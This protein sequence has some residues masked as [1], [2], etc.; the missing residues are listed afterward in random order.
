LNFFDEQTATDLEFDDI[1]LLLKD[2]C[3]NE[4][5]KFWS[6]KIRPFRT[7]AQAEEALMLTHELQLIRNRGLTFPRLE[8]NE[9]QKEIR[10]LEITA[11]VL[12]LQSIVNIW[13]ASKL[14]NSL[15]L[16]FKEER[17]YTFLPSLL[18]GAFFTK[19]IDAAIEKI[20][21]KRLE[22]KDDASESLFQIRQAIHSTKRK[23]SRNFERALKSAQKQGYI[24]DINESV[25]DDRR[26]LSINSTFKRQ[27]EGNILGNSK[28]G[29]LTYIEPRANEK[30]NNELA[31]L[32]DDERKEIQKIF[33]E[34]TNFLRGFYDLIQVY[35]RAL[36]K[37]DFINA[38][39]WLAAKMDAVKPQINK[40]GTETHLHDAYHPL[41]LL[42]NNLLGLKTFPQ[43]FQ[44]DKDQ[45]IMVISGPNAGGK[46]ITLK[47]LGIL[48][49]MFQSGLLV[50][51][52]SSS[53]FSWYNYILS[54]IGDN[55]SIE[56]QLS[57]YSY[58]LQ[59][60]KFFLDKTSPKTLLL[61][62]E[63]GTGSDPD[64]G[65]ALAEVF[66]ETI[67]EKGCY[68]VI[69]THYTNI[70]LKASEL[71]EAFNANMLFN[72]KTLEPEY[73]LSVGQAGSSFTFEVAE[74]N[75]IPNELLQSAKKKI[76]RNK[77]KLDGLISDLQKEKSNLK[78][79]RKKFS[80]KIQET[81]KAKS[82]FEKFQNRYD[83]RLRV[84]QIR[85]ERNDKYLGH[86]KKM[87]DFIDRFQFNGGQKNKGLLN[88]VRKYITIEKS[89]IVELELK[90]VEKEKEK[91][92]KS[93]S[94]KP[95]KQLQT[96]KRPIVKGSRVKLKDSKQTG[97]VIELE[98]K[99]AVVTFGMF[100]TKVSTDKLILIDDLKTKK[101]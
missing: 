90:K 1:R 20:L 87:S 35:Q 12:E 83:E 71:A 79:E 70:K 80:E 76:D 15:M 28:T 94:K 5:A 19:E 49:L 50:C 81:E 95:K 46:S 92:K 31:Q 89:K 25:I 69:T 18:E 44:L 100:K 13:D 54:D 73:Q 48:Q 7:L 24:S 38:K 9:L 11:S 39:V 75:G 82:E 42:K 30:L 72:K 33:S 85:I 45:R 27:V 86:G 53:R 66:F 57:T 55:Q 63:F 41:L 77:L 56:N 6:T 93:A 62:D 10:M 64:L 61:L 78:E 52:S 32:R 99:E 34:L 8:F 60:M 47:T 29:S 98:G 84:Q 88:E 51:A 96:K 26:V 16:F 14:V 59:R 67:Y 91:L 36:C 101:N 97:E 74:M 4:T 23:I 2:L 37:F 40:D 68:G 65:G 17:E 58:R 21:D 43:S 3:K 22:V